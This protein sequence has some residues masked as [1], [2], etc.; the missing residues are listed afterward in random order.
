MN[1]WWLSLSVLQ[2]VMFVIGA[3]TLL[4]MAA[5]IIMMLVG[6]G[7]HELSD[8]PDLSAFEGADALDGGDLNADIVVANVDA[9]ADID[10]GADSDCGDGSVVCTHPEGME[11]LHALGLRMLSLRCIITFFCFGSWMTFIMDSY[12]PWYF[13]VLIGVAVGFVAAVGMALLMNEMMKLQRDGTIKHKNCE[14]KQGDVYLAVPARRSG[15]G[16]VNVLVQESYAEFTAVTDDDEIIPT[17]EKIKVVKAEGNILV[18]ERLND[19][20]RQSKSKAS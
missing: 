6:L 16:K 11:H 1:E 7:G 20:N 18:V 9:G 5:Q 14:G 4:F 17:G 10:A 12:M 13:A 19:S 15:E 2:Q 8:A 3:A